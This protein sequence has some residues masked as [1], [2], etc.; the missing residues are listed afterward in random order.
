M[1]QAV[2]QSGPML[3]AT[4]STIPGV[5]QCLPRGLPENERDRLF[6]EFLKWSSTRYDQA[7]RPEQRGARDTKGAASFHALRRY[8]RPRRQ[9]TNLLPGRSQKEMNSLRHNWLERFNPEL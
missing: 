5:A 7:D 3:G 4:S 2:A 1:A 8:H 9:R 6:E